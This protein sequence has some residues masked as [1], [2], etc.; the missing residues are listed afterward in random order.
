MDSR[1]SK[2]TPLPEKPMFLSMR[3]STAISLFESSKSQNSCG[4]FVNKTQCPCCK[5]RAILVG[6]KHVRFMPV[7]G[8]SAH[9]LPHG[10][11]FA[12]KQGKLYLPMAVWLLTLVKLLSA[13][14]RQVAGSL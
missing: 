4:N 8:R 14:N 13:F 2:H 5:E 7:N 10:F 9:A 6:R 11:F 3:S 12:N 1:L